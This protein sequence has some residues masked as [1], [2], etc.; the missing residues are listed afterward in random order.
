MKIKLIVSHVDSAIDVAAALKKQ[1][2]R[3]LSAED[4]TVYKYHFELTVKKFKK[5]ITDSVI[6]PMFESVTDDE[7]IFKVI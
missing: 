1:P 5:L 4:N 7:M 3:K 2:E 6:V